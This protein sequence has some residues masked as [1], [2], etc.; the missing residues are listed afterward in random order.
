ML[1]GGDGGAF[2]FLHKAEY[3]PRAAAPFVKSWVERM[4]GE[5]KAENRQA[6]PLLIDYGQ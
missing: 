1:E 2:V 3:G 6:N 4:G 5:T